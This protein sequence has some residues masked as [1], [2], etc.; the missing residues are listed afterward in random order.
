MVFKLNWI[1][2][3]EQIVKYFREFI[4]KLDTPSIFP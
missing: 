4:S 3:T 2:G 1:K